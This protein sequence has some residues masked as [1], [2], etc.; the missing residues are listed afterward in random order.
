[1]TVTVT[2]PDFNFSE[3]DWNDVVTNF[4]F[5]AICAL[6]ASAGSKKASVIRHWNNPCFQR[7]SQKSSR[8]PW[9]QLLSLYLIPRMVPP[10]FWVTASLASRKR[11]DFDEDAEML[12]FFHPLSAISQRFF[13]NFF[14]D[15]LVTFQQNMQQNL[16]FALSDL[17]SQRSFCDYVLFGVALR[18][19]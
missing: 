17:K 2:D 6:S 18:R 8:V 10:L 16:R 14:C 9:R 12:R 5:V 7:K 1:M 13:C 3:L 19:R 4:N 15:F 11:C